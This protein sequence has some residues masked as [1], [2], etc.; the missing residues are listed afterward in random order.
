[1]GIGINQIYDQEE[2][3]DSTFNGE[4][5]RNEFDCTLGAKR[6]RNSWKRGD[7]VQEC[8]GKGQKT[9][10]KRVPKKEPPGSGDEFRIERPAQRGT[11]PEPGPIITIGRKGRNRKGGLFLPYGEGS[12]ED[13]KS[14]YGLRHRRSWPKKKKN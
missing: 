4:K 12:A 10:T 2:R 1:M 9:I 6:I 3:R 8:L 5:T 7:A 11:L 13:S 14:Q